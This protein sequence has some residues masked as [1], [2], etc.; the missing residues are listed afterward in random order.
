MKPATIFRILTI[1]LVLAVAT[2]ATA[3]DYGLN[4]DSLSSIRGTDPSFRNR[5]SLFIRS[6]PATRLDGP[7][8]RWAIEGNL[9]NRIV[10]DG[11]GG[12]DSSFT[13]DLDL[14]RAQIIAPNIGGNP[15]VLRATLGRFLFSDPTRLILVHP[16][17][18]ARLNLDLR[19]VTLQLSGAYT[20]LLAGQN[21]GIAMTIDDS[22]DA[23]DEDTYASANRIL[24]SAGVSGP[25]LIGRTSISTG[26]FGQIDLRPDSSALQ[27]LNSYY[28][29]LMF[30]G[31]VIQDLNYE[32]AVVGS[33]AQRFTTP[34][35]TTADTE[36]G[37]ATMARLRYFLG[38]AGSSIITLE[39]LY[40]TPEGDT[41]GRFVPI[42][43]PSLNLL[44][45]P[46]TPA[47][48]SLLLLDYTLNPFAGRPG[49]IARSLQVSAYSAVRASGTPFQEGSYQSTELGSRLTYRPFSDLGL[50]LWSALLLP[51]DNDPEFRGRFELS[52]SL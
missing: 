8:F 41:L 44:G 27:K 51:S 36:L 9:T 47:D 34:D 7:T 28:S 35:I 12:F 16:A 50:R 19:A 26:F 15:I 4:V 6:N 23:A 2:T 49:A 1:I 18:G 38:Q 21:S 40:G 37:L 30:E 17:D 24:F 31:P 48:T 32:V 52:L 25:D 5:A 3:V 22:L 39:G 29:W 43:P 42:T 20:G 45:R 13:P 33:L 46:S 10:P 14:A 11:D